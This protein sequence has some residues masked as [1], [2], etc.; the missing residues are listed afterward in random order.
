MVHIT[1]DRNSYRCRF[2]ALAKL[3]SK[4]KMSLTRQ[5][6]NFS[7]GW[8]VRAWHDKADTE[9]MQA[10][11]LTILDNTPD[12]VAL[13]DIEEGACY[14]NRAGRRLLRLAV[15]S[16]R[17]ERDRFPDT[18]RHAAYLQEQLFPIGME[19]G[20][21]HGERT[22]KTQDGNE[23]PVS[24][25][26]IAHHDSQGR[27]SYLSTIARDITERKA[28]DAQM[29]QQMAV[30]QEQKARLEKQKAELMQAGKA[31]AEAY[32][33]QAEAN[34]RLQTLA[35]TDGLTGL[36]NHRAFQEQLANEF[37]RAVRYQ[38]PLSLLLLDVDRFKNYNDTFGHPAGDEV[39]RTVA[40]TLQREGRY[41]DFSARYGGEEFVIIL[42]ETDRMGAI[43]AAERLRKAIAAQP[44]ERLA[45]TV[46]VG[47]ATFRQDMASP[48]TLIEEADRALYLSKECGRN[49]VTH[50]D[51][52]LAVTSQTK[53]ITRP[54]AKQ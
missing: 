2:S 15:E 37:Q 36:W 16:A 34:Y 9:M 6:T 50:Y 5:L 48:A 47:V 18:S 25:V 13:F 49:C 43:E 53:A 3:L 20:S 22:L 28:L 26:V 11:L 24:Q 45:V 35:T 29:Q 10:R 4:L 12:L 39:L 17:D 38:S 44:W 7:N 41:N 30:I 46:S 51:S 1:N 21:W 40:A 42:P 23:I 8:L 32:F 33:D 27:L 31:I 54:V 14:C 52:L 19:R